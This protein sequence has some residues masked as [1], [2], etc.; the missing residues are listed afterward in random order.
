MS[1]SIF[2]PVTQLDS[3]FQTCIARGRLYG[4]V[5]LTGNRSLLPLAFGWASSEKGEFTDM[6]FDMIHN[7][8]H[9]I[10]CCHTDEALALINS[11]EKV[12][13]ENL[14]CTW[15]MSHHCP[16]KQA[17]ISLVKSKTPQEYEI[18][19]Q[20]IIKSNGNLANYLNKKSR[21]KKNI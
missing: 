15:H 1:S 18:K 10:K 2:F 4:L 21:W 13:I 12:G 6:L 8:L 3:R 19:K 20:N 7:E 9:F 14:L 16:D 17:F 5:T 11:V